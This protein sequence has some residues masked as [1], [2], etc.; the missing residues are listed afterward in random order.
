MTVSS[1]I[2]SASAWLN[3]SNVLY[4]VG[5]GLTVITALFV[6]YENRAI[7]SGKR[8]KLYLA[9]EIAVVLSAIMS[10][11]G[12]IGAIHYGNVV[13]SLKDADLTTYKTS[14][15]V[16]ITQ[17]E[18]DADIAY[19]LAA[20][21]I[22]DAGMANKESEETKQANLRLQIDL[23]THKKQEKEIEAQLA[24][25]KSVQDVAQQAKLST[26]ATAGQFHTAQ[27]A[28]VY[29]DQIVHGRDFST[30]ERFVVNFSIKNTGLT[31]ALHLHSDFHVHM[32]GTGCPAPTII[33][34]PLTSTA[35]I[36][37]GQIY[38]M[39]GGFWSD[40]VTP[41]CLNALHDGTATY[42]ISGPIYYTDEFGYDH[43]TNI[44][45]QY[46]YNDGNPLMAIAATGNDSN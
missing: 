46:F 32:A 19:K 8:A 22:R 16:K 45:L 18:A 29:L 3:A 5:S 41:D 42:N 25:K 43:I 20:Q 14:A 23:D 27:R 6:L 31:T 36:A 30:T 15:D 33:P 35:D 7:A 10:L 12:S 4:I 21:A 39:N 11:T 44:N 28:R 40:P 26:Q 9:S 2:D 34:S 38:Y 24:T 1:P 17:S 37:A 13:S